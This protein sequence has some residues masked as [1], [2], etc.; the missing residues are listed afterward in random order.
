MSLAPQQY[1]PRLLDATVERKLRSFGAI[2]IAGTKFCGKTWTS[3]AHSESIAHIDNDSIRQAVELDVSLALEGET[4]HTI[5]EWQDVPKIWDAVR[6]R[7]DE[8]GNAKGQFILTGSS[9]VDKTKVSHSGAGRIA[10]LHM[11]PMSLFENGYSNGSVSL[12]GL[13]NGKFHASPVQ[14]SARTIAKAICQGGWPA[15]CECDDDLLGDIPA[16]YLDALFNVSTVKH[17]LN[18]QT[19]RRVAVSLARNIG[20]PVTYKTLYLDT[21]EESDAEKINSSISQQK[22]E[23]YI[24]FLKDQYTIEDQNGWAAPIKSRSRVRTKPKRSFV[25]PSL[26]ASLLGMSPERLLMEMQVFRTLF[27]ELCVRDVRIYASALQQTPEPSVYYYSDADGL[28]VDIIVE[29]T[30]GQWGA[31]EVKLSEEKVPQAEKN[32]LRL[33]EKVAANPAAHNQEPAFLAVLV[34][35][36]SFCRQLP[37]GVYA[38]PITSLGA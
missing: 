1:R 22:L 12:K 14:T 35:M 7:V 2:E 37:S 32:L 25:D 26:P 20:K 17:G 5:D 27:E 24:S 34:G 9:T 6:R 31:F 11:R 36:A 4:P 38:I 29:L 23:P 28:E 33:K 13:F 19:A 8:S 16:Q 10:T 18:R 21:F 30:N 15:A 3:L